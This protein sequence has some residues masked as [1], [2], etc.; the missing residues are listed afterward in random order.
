METDRDRSLQS[1]TFRTLFPPRF[2]SSLVALATL[3]T[4]VACALL[5]EVVGLLAAPAGGARGR[6][7]PACVLRGWLPYHALVLCVAAALLAGAVAHAR[8]VCAAARAWLL[9]P[10]L[11]R[12][13]L[14][15]AALRSEGEGRERM[16]CAVC[17]DDPA[18]LLVFLPCGHRCVCATCADLID[19]K[20]PLCRRP[21]EERVALVGKYRIYV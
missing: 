20:C 17:F 5:G 11:S 19:P 15:A 14:E 18:Q 13:K 3:S 4:C 2:L 12:R 8:R 7:G 10:A 21:I 16:E 6:A 1:W 9:K